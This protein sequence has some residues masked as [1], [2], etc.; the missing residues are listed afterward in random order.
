MPITKPPVSEY[1]SYYHTYVGKVNHNNLIDALRESSGD[2]IQFLQ[3]IPEEKHDYRYAEGKWT[4]KEVVAHIIDCERVFIYRALSF[5]RNDKTELPF[6]DENA[7]APQSNAANRTMESLI[8]EYQSARHANIAFFEG[9]TDEMAL[10]KGKANG[11][12]ISVRSLGFI[13]SGHELHHQ[14]VIKERYL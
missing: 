1:P 9:I 8:D 11:N 10:R 4:V 6:F 14:Q 5:S 3:D 13:L 2:F 7:W 12:E